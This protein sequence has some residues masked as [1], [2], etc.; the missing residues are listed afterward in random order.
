ML[1]NLAIVVLEYAV[2]WWAG[3]L[4]LVAD[5]S[6]NLTDVTGLLL[7]LGAVWLAGRLPNARYTY[8]M[9][10]ATIIA[11]LANGLLLIFISGA[12]ALQAFHRFTMPG[13]I[14]AT[15]VIVVALFGMVANLA[16]AR[17][18]H[19][20]HHDDLNVRG[21]Y[22]HML[23]DAGVSLSVAI[24]ALAMQQT[25]LAWIDPLLT[26]LIVVAI[27]VGSWKLLRD[28]IELA[29]QGVPRGVD[30]NEI[31]NFL[32]LQY[33]VAEVHELHVWGLS[34][35]EVALT[36]HLV[37]PAGHPG[38]AFIEALTAGLEELGVHHATIQIETTPHHAHSAVHAGH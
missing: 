4:S 26:L 24:G 2:G 1:F 23:G 14:A 8:G 7:A 34:T 33:G 38:D 37:M 13:E 31:R 15:P 3:S 12:L 27:V 28:S 35:M 20:H 17:L 9:G 30:L 16:T 6:H 25:G 10:G 22:I 18:F 21:A 32:T 5:A 11:A 19:G 36:V 29:L